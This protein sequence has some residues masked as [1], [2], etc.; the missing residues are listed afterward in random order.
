[1]L[2]IPQVSTAYRH[3]D[4]NYSKI[5]EGISR[6]AELNP[7]NYLAFFPSYDFLKKTASF[8]WCEQGCVVQQQR[9]MS[10]EAVE[11][12]GKC[13]VDEEQDSIVLAVQ[14]S[15]FSEGVDYN[16]PRLK[17]VFVVGPA[18]PRISFERE[19]LRNYYQDHFGN[20]FAYAYAYPSM[21]RSIQASG[22]AIRAADKKGLL[23]LMDGRFLSVP[24]VDSIPRFWYQDSP[25]E[26]VSKQITADVREFWR[27]GRV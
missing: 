9:G 17:G 19:L 25:R 3:R 18:L 1:M 7:G 22:R 13:F 5:G 16:S 23:V 20:G 11:D 21:I 6:I 15:I 24:Y 4:R 26:L 14:G 2:I 27:E 8:I 12:L 10:Q